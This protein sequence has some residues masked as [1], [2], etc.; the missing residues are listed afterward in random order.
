MTIK[1]RK[2]IYKP[3]NPNAKIEQTYD[4][5][6][7][8][9]LF[10]SL[11][12]NAICLAPRQRITISTGI[13]LELPPGVEAQIRPRSGLASA[14]GITVLNSPGTIDNHYRGEIKV[15]LINLG[16]KRY[17]IKNGEKIAQL[18]FSKLDKF[19]VC[20]PKSIPIIPIKGQRELNGL[21]SSD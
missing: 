11:G 10:A 12:V 20:D 9:D 7:G 14:H 19:D 21:G 6:S 13:A 1:Q 4:G 2:I 16:N 17:Y 15:I 3:L 18:C 5:D 8:Y